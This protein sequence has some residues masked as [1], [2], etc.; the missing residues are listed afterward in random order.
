MNRSGLV[1]EVSDATGLSRNDVDKVLNAALGA[2]TNALSNEDKVSLLGFGSFSVR[3]R[4]A[5]QGR[6]PRTGAAQTIPASNR[7]HFSAGANLKRAV[8]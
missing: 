5:R 2:I 3:H 8:N 1:K 4:K 7:V 6:N